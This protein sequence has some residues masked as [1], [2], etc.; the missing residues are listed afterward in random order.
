MLEY[1]ALPFIGFLI[2]LLIV[3]IGG[4]G[5][6]LYLGVLTAFFG[7]PT[8][9]AVTTSLATGLATTAMG[10]YSHW[11]AGNVNKTLGLIMLASASVAAVFGSLLSNQIPEQAYIKITGVVML[12]LVVH[13]AQAYVR[14]RRRGER[15]PNTRPTPTDTAK[16][17][18]YGVFGG[19]LSGVMGLSGGIPIIAGLMLLGCSS[20]ETVGTSVFVLVGMAAVS[21][22]MHLA[23]GAVDWMLVIL[24]S[25]GAVLGAWA[26]PRL[27]ARIDKHTLELVLQP[28]VMVLCTIMG[29]M[30]LLR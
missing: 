15:S 4:G 8:P 29:V 6:S 19:L 10:S 16:A 25:S 28:A 26:S 12:G 27:L 2:G 13:M 22:G 23:T 30:L 18:A 21:F 17:I 24:M 7:V 20:L 3:S 14:R 5:G 9:V 11:R 1:A